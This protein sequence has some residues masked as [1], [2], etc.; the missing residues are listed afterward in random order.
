[1]KI[2]AIRNL[3][4][5]ALFAMAAMLSF[6][7]G[8]SAQG[9]TVTVSIATAATSSG[10]CFVPAGSTIRFIVSGTWAGTTIVQKSIDGG[11]TFSTV[12]STTANINGFDTAP[13]GNNTLYNVIFATR[14]SGTVTGSLTGQTYKM[15]RA[16][17]ETVPIGQVAYTS[18]GSSQTVVAGSIYGADLVVGGSAATPFISTGGAILNGATAATDL[19]IYI[20]YDSAGNVVANTALAGTLSANANVFQK[21]VWTSPVQLVPGE[22][23]LAWQS[24][25]STA[26]FRSISTATNV[27]VLTESQTGVFATLAPLTINTTIP[28]VAG[29][30]PIGYIY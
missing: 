20:L 8:A 4:V 3:I 24:N 6:A 10:N 25:G 7:P 2:P 21:I 9:C 19:L 12:I 26:T 14:T 11:N 1:M 23:H 30:G 28:P 5:S 15:S 17:F 27:N 16:A 22:Y 13:S 18:A 29:L